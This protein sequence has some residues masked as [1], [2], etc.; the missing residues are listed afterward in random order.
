[1]LKSFEMLRGLFGSC[2]ARQVG[3]FSLCVFAQFTKGPPKQILSKGKYRLY[4]N[5]FIHKGKKLHVTLEDLEIF[6]RETDKQKAN[7]RSIFMG[8]K[9]AL[10]F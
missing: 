7:T 9:M 6:D 10:D 3:I 5:T 8:C 1:M 4:I 2:W